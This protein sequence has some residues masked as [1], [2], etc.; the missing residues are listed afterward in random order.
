MYHRMIWFAAAAEKRQR[1]QKNEKRNAG[2]RR[3]GT[4]HCE[5]FY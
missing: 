5:Q 1:K 3:N 2:V 4:T